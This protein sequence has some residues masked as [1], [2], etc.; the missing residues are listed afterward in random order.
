MN[1][2]FPFSIP[3]ALDA[4]GASTIGSFCIR[5]TEFRFLCRLRGRSQA[6]FQVCHHAY[7]KHL[8]QTSRIGSVIS[9]PVGTH[10]IVTHHP[11]R[12][13][14]Q[15]KC[16]AAGRVATNVDQLLHGSGV[17]VQTASGNQVQIGRIPHAVFHAGQTA[18]ASMCVGLHFFGLIPAF[19]SWQFA[20]VGAAMVALAVL[21]LALPA[22]IN[23]PSGLSLNL[24]QMLIGFG[25]AFILWLSIIPTVLKSYRERLRIVG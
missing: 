21:S 17:A 11:L 5:N 23:L 24:R 12:P 8:P 7:D 4:P 14:H 19:K 16:L 3:I 1:S 10:K 18:F 22:Y 2:L 25:S 6:I 15:F 9:R 20:A 13:R